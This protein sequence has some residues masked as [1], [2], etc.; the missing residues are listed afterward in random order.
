[1]PPSFTPEAYRAVLQSL[2]AE[3]WV[4]FTERRWWPQFAFHYT[5][6]RNAVNIL[7]EGKILSRLRAE[8]QGKIAVS[9]GSAEVLAGTDW[10]I[11]D[12]VRLYFR[13]KTPTQ[14]NAEGVHSHQTLKESKFPDAHCP[15]PV[16][17][18]FDL[19]GILALPE[20]RFSN[21]NLASR[22][23]Q[24][25]KSPQELQNLPWQQIY[26]T[27][28]IDWNNPEIAREI[29]ARRNA[30]IIVPGELDLSGLKYIYCRSEA[31]KDTLLHLLPPPIR[32][33]YRDK[34]VASN[35]NELYFRRRTF[36]ERAV[37]TDTQ[38]FLRFSADAQ[39]PGPF[40]LRVEVQTDKAFTR[41]NPDFCLPPYDYV[42]PL[43]RTLPAYQVR[44]MLD[45]ALVY[46]NAFVDSSLPF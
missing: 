32:A 12:C 45:D 17:L 9:S 46:A 7:Q 11:K 34:I 4:R 38:I 33:R 5:D 26:H 43:P 8:Q 31:E 19:P 22:G 39:A 24:L 6:I 41:E 25:L 16:F 21:Q 14:F 37:L 42:L 30:E 29:V 40:R 1:M 23:Y 44:V 3:R 15:V 35:R 10:N 13:P 20:S 36:V 27:E 28:R 18:L 2:E